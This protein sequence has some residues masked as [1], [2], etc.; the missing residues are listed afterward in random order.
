MNTKYSHVDLLITQFIFY[1]IKSYGY[2]LVH[3]YILV[4]FKIKTHR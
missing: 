3:K 4:N 1:T 2:K